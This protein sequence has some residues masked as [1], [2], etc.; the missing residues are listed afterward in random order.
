MRKIKP[1]INFAGVLNPGMRVFDVIM[2]TEYGTSYNSYV[3]K[4]AEKTAI[5]EASHRGFSHLYGQILEEA[6]EGRTPEYLILNHTEP[7]HSGSVACLLEKYPGLQVFCSQA[8]AI[9]LKNIVNRE[10]FSPH[11]VRDG[12]SLDLGGTTLK[13]ISA[14]FLHWPDSIFTYL[15]EE[16]TVFSCDFL[17]AHYCEPGVLD[18]EIV[19]GPEYFGALKYYYDCIF[20]PFAP[21]V[22]AGLQKLKSLEFDTVCPSHGPVLTKDGVL[23]RVLELY[24]GWSAEKQAGPARIPIFYCSA[25]GNTK[26]LAQAV[27]EGILNAIPDANAPLYNIIE[28]DLSALAEEL[29]GSGAF[30][31][32][33]PTINREAVPPAWQL[34]S[35]ADAVNIQKRPVAL[36][37][38][39]GWSG[40]A[41][42][43]LA[44]RLSSLKCAVFGQQLKVCFVPTDEDLAAAKAFGEAFAKQI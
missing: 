10:G 44:E 14:P 7:D 43:H 26:S 22:R 30:L 35:L 12:D 5:I 23:G 27:R 2:R 24:E 3:V 42:P 9:Y 33:S 40:E 11:I 39:F 28:H 19:Y 41:L 6:L 34:L 1:S 29:N 32:G 17:G 21:Y 38:S 31:I 4:G 13:F 20:G 8:A 16:K 25:Y 37:G 15:P 18:Q 36:F